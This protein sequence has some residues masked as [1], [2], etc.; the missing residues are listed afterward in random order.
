[1]PRSAYI[2]DKSVLRLKTTDCDDL[3]KSLN[4][5]I[6]SCNFIRVMTSHISPLTL[7]NTRCQ[8]SSIVFSDKLR[9]N[10]QYFFMNQVTIIT[11][12]GCE[13]LKGP[14]SSFLS[15]WKEPFYPANTNWLIEPSSF[16][17]PWF[18]STPATLIHRCL[19]EF[20]NVEVLWRGWVIW[21]T[22]NKA[23]NPILELNPGCPVDDRIITW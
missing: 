8:V 7:F 10:Y 15:Q 6:P 13:C 2:F 12:Y 21:T 1:M 14:S 9:I 5:N 17:P 4:R 22:L 16:N 11:C 18:L 23:M 3:T 20:S 19:D